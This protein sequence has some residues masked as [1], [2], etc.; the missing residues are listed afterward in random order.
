ME[1]EIH[2]LYVDDDEGL[3]DLVSTVLEREFE[4][5]VV[6]TRSDPR[7]AVSVLTGDALTFDCILS[8]YRMP[9]IDGL[10]FFE[11]CCEVA[12][13]TPFILYTGHGDES[14]ASEAIGLGVTD[15]LTKGRGDHHFRRVG[16]R[17]ERAVERRW[18][19]Q[20][21][22]EERWQ[23]EALVEHFPQG[24]VATFDTEFRYQLAG[25][26]AYQYLPVEPS[27]LRGVPM[28]EVH[29][30]SS[31]SVLEDAYERVMA[32][33]SEVFD[34]EYGGQDWMVRALPL[35]D[36]DG[37]VFGG[38]VLAQV[39]EDHVSVEGSGVLPGRD[40]NSNKK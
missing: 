25:G 5:L 27:E 18:V 22:D 16:N 34:L 26:E 31:W 39:A 10:D 8:D 20:E 24:L 30:E 12:P 11:Q 1:R 35:R 6:T 36:S 7:D 13:E 4:Q 9:Q 21:R 29:P 19:E 23:A 38:L 32:G 2:V 37:A 33:E 40:M 17:V 28:Y 15:Y 14:L 3:R